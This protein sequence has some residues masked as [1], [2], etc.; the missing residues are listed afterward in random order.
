MAQ[1]VFAL[2]PLRR[3]LF[4]RSVQKK[5]HSE[6][7]SDRA[8]TRGACMGDH[9]I[10]MSVTLAFQKGHTLYTSEQVQS[11]CS[12]EL[13]MC[14]AAQQPLEEGQCKAISYGNR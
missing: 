6:V 3:E 14:A 9:S 2:T 13:V 12:A 10:L 7:L 8:S 5:A 11:L 1:T 4:F